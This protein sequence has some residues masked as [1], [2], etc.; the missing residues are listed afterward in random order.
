MEAINIDT[1]DEYYTKIVFADECPPCECCGE[2]F[3][4]TCFDHYADCKCFGP[5]Q[6]GVIY[7]EFNGVLYGRSDGEEE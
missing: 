1:P 4:E 2:P 5:T 6:D 3:C 7:K